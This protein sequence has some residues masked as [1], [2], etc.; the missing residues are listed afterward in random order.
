MNS[1]KYFLSLLVLAS[2]LAACATVPTINVDKTEQAIACLEHS[3]SCA[4]TVAILLKSTDLAVIQQ[5]TAQVEQC[6]ADLGQMGC[7]DLAQSLRQSTSQ[8]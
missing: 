1:L 5:A 7:K 8:K 6:I 2:C 3:T 4:A